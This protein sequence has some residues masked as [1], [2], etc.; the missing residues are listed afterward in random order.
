VIAAVGAIALF[1]AF[2]LALLGERR[3]DSML[4]WWFQRPMAAL[5]AWFAAAVLFGGFLVYAGF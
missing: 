3:V 4:Q 5:R 1:A 2:V